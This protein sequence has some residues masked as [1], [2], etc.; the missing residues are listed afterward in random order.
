MR[1]WPLFIATRS[2]SSIKNAHFW[3][4]PSL[5]ADSIGGFQF[6]S[7]Y[8][9]KR[10][11]TTFSA[12]ASI[13]LEIILLALRSSPFCITRLWAYLSPPISLDNHFEQRRRQQQ[14][15]QHATI[16]RG[17][18]FIHLK[19]ITHATFKPDVILSLFT[20][21][22]VRPS[23]TTFSSRRNVHSHK[24]LVFGFLCIFNF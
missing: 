10:L 2:F 6:F 13:W 11:L 21:R 16:S 24:N 15:L 12:I 5:R 20:G 4:H 9:H 7:R 8:P 17:L 19:G 23:A 1:R 14:H 22:Y 3:V 18:I